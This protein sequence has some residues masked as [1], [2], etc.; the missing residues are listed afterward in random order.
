HRVAPHRRAS[1]T[2]RH[3]HAPAIP[4]R[5]VRVPDGPTRLVSAVS[6][7][8]R[9]ADARYPQHHKHAL[10]CRGG[11][12]PD[13]GTCCSARAST[14]HRLRLA[15]QMTTVEH[16]PAEIVAAKT[17]PAADRAG[18]LAGVPRG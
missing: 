18:L 16:T 15:G 7:A 6:G 2:P 5:L 3:A 14:K 12:G 1:S 10:E 9:R 11:Q 13:P 8:F 17:D 4:Q